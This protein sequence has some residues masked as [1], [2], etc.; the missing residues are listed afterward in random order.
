MPSSVQ[1]KDF[2]KRLEDTIRCIL[3]AKTVID[4]LLDDGSPTMAQLSIVG[5]RSSV[6]G[7]API[8]PV[9]IKVTPLRP[10]FKIEDDE[11]CFRGSKCAVCLVFIKRTISSKLVSL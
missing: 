8:E 3:P 6:I 2:A 7:G 1:I 5:K 4:L 10:L 11:K 9:K